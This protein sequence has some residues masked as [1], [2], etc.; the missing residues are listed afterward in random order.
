MANDTTDGF[1]AGPAYLLHNFEHRAY[2]IPDDRPLT[3]GRD[4]A[5][6][7]MV[8]EVF[9]SRHHAELRR[10]GDGYTL[11]PVGSTPTV[12]N[13][14]PIEAPHQLREGDVFTIGTMKFGF[15]RDRLPVAMAV[16]EPARNILTGVD[17]RRP[18]LT[19]KVAGSSNNRPKSP[20]I[21][22]VVLAAVLLAVIAAIIRFR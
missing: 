3:I 22:W 4:A 14:L 13:D 10:D 1:A 11:F 21:V 8:N 12:V 16:A 2:A 17:D 18:T 9:V 5:C 6:D 19:F 15:T 20:V 7:I